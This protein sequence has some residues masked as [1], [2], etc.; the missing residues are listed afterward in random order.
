MRSR[1]SCESYGMSRR[2]VTASMPSIRRQIRRVKMSPGGCVMSPPGDRVIS[3]AGLAA[4]GPN[5]DLLAGKS[6]E[7]TIEQLIALLHPIG[8]ARRH[9]PIAR[10]FR[11]E[12]NQR[13]HCRHAALFI[14]GNRHERVVLRKV[15]AQRA[16]VVGLAVHESR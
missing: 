3:V 9:R 16:R 15:V 12:I 14:E 1:S 7:Q 8:H 5:A 2:T 10:V 11:P 13:R 4:S 6:V